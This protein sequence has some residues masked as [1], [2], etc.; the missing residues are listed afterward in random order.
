MM[1][2]VAM[3]SVDLFLLNSC[4]HVGCWVCASCLD[5]DREEFFE[6]VLPLVSTGVVEVEGKQV[7]NLVEMSVALWNRF[8]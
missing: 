5:E 6:F 4:G 1:S 2:S 8:P 3:A 7:A